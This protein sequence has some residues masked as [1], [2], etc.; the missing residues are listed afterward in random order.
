M[1][2]GESKKQYNLR[3]QWHD[4]FAWYPII[5]EDGRRCWLEHINRKFLPGIGWLYKLDNE[6]IRVEK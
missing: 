2:W 4:W 3:C 1:L 5:L 6:D